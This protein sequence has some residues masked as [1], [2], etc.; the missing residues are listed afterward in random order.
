MAKAGWDRAYDPQTSGAG[1]TYTDENGKVIGKFDGANWIHAGAEA[2]GL[3]TAQM[4][5]LVGGARG[6]YDFSP[7]TL[8]FNN[9]TDQTYA[10]DRAMKAGGGD[11]GF[12]DIMKLGAIIAAVYTGGAALGAWGGAEAATAGMEVGMLGGGVEAAATADTIAS[13]LVSAGTQA[14]SAG[15]SNG[16][17]PSF[18]ETAWTGI[19]NTV[20]SWF[21]PVAETGASTTAQA[22]TGGASTLDEAAQLASAGGNAG[23][24]AGAA[25]KSA[26]IGPNAAGWVGETWKDLSPYAKYGVISGGMNVLGGA[27]TGIGSGLL[28]ASATE[29]R[30]SADRELA[31]LNSP[32]TRADVARSTMAS[33]GAFNQNLGFTPGPAQ[34]LRRP[35]GTLVFAPGGGIIAGGMRR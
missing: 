12:G 26:G 30:I 23:T 16:G 32:A 31:N 25:A 4:G 27:I 18:L 19:K 6:Q 10:N 34:T 8:G 5:E 11:D 28:N 17:G 22:L 33:S 1:Y 3:T 14:A 21:T 20:G 29:K 24:V 35:D 9:F 7:Q 2:G 15:L 13:G